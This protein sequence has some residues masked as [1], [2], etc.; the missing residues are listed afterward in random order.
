MSP[1]SRLAALPALLLACAFFCFLVTV[2]DVPAGPK[3]TPPQAIYHKDREH[4]WNRVHAAFFVRTGPDDRSYGEDRLEPL[5]WSESKYLLEGKTA[6][7][8]AAVLGE[9]LRDKGEALIDDPL[10]RA[11]LQRDLW[12]VSNWLAGKPD[13]DRKRLDPLLAQVIRRLALTSEQIAKLPDN[14]AATVASKKH[15]DRFDAEKP[16]RSYLPAD[17]FM[18]DGPWVCVGRTDGPTA[19]FHLREDGGSRFTNSA[20]LI[21]LKLPGSRDKTLEFLKT[22]AAFDKPLVLPNA[23]EKTK[24]SLSYLPNPAMPQWP[25]GTEVAL[26]RRAMLIDSS[27]KVV[28]SPLTESVQLRAMST[29]APTLTAETIDKIT[30]RKGTGGQAF[31]EFRLSRAEVFGG[32]TG[33][34]L[35]VSGERDFKTGFNAHPW[36]EF[37]QSPN[38]DRPFPQRA[39]PFATN[40]ASCI[41]CH[42]P[43]GVYGFNSIQGFAFG[44]PGI[45]RNED[46]DELE[47]HVL[48]AM[49]VEKVEKAAVKWKEGQPGWVALRKLLP[50]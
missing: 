37:D 25:T 32:K 33:G 36:D 7:R 12:L 27:R 1:L 24:R 34:L 8:A 41:G 6:D 47:R 11:I 18:T 9:F 38:K 14:Y 4:L 31:A 21:F 44:L 19:P 26:V 40:R 23:D 2:A 16:E 3:E 17:M 45:V 43:P 35:D 49:T 13:D 50:E 28:V 15:A 22:L 10:K 20:F 30:G 5:L 29:D 42:S 46:G 39:M 48:A